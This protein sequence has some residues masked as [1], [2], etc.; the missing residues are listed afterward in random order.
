MAADETRIYHIPK[1]PPPIRGSFLLV[2]G[3]G[4][5]DESVGFGN[6]HLQL[7]R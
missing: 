3:E 1:S 2:F 5:E 7:F 4:L 6:L